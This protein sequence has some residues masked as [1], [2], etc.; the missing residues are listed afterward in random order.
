MQDAVSWDYVMAIAVHK[1][2]DPVG[3]DNIS[4]SLLKVAAPVIAEPLCKISNKSLETGI[5][6]TEFKNAKVF[7]VYKKD[8][9]SDA[10]LLQKLEFYGII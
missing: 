6:P 1:F 2:L 4:V 9:K 8:D 10:I 7:P 3:L 5:F